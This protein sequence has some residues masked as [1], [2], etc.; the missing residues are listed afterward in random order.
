[1][2]SISFIQYLYYLGKAST[3][4]FHEQQITIGKLIHN[5]YCC[6]GDKV[7]NTSDPSHIVFSVIQ[8][9]FRNIKILTVNNQTSL[10]NLSTLKNIIM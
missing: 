5:G 1:M 9:I 6:I 3:K 2:F 10:E 7:V 8:A 4:G